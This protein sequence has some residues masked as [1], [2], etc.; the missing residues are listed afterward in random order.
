M[1]VNVVRR[2]GGKKAVNMGLIKLRV[3]WCLYSREVDLIFV[4]STG[5]WLEYELYRTLEI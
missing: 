4:N 1:E 5:A 2:H 3:F